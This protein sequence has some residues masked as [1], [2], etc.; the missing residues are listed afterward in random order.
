MFA[1]TLR[2]LRKEKG[3]TQIQF[4]RLFSVASGTIAMWETGKREPDFDTMQ[5]L[6]D[7]FGVTVDY[8]LGRDENPSYGPAPGRSNKKGGWVPV[9][10]RV[11]AGI[12]VE[13]V[14]EVLGYEEIQQDLNGPE[15]YFALQV[16]GDSMEPKISNGDVVIV[17]K[18]EDCDNG[19]MAVVLVNNGQATVKK[20]KKS[21]SGVMLIPS[22]PAF[23][24]MFYSNDD[25]ENLPV[26][27]LGKV[28]ELRA[29]F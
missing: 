16:K 18:Q 27:I 22:N 6:A 2:Q 23:E 24:P 1:Q 19:D 7:F 17:R 4:A 14:E 20:I 21:P 25:I 3:L 15:E 8:L 13:A 29:K 26:V 10:G 11:Q 5:R 9:I 28:V 12:P